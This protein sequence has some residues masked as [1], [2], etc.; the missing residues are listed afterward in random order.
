M[1]Y[2]L[3]SVSKAAVVPGDTVSDIAL[4]DMY[5]IFAATSWD[6]SIYYYDANDALGHKSTTKLGGPLLSGSFCDGNKM[7]AGAV[8][9]MLYVVDVATNQ[10]SEIKAHDLGI[11]KT[12]VYNNIVITGSW[13]KKL[14][15]W[16]LRSNTPLFTH[17]LAHK[18]YAMDI[19]ND[20]LVLALSNNTV[21]TYNINDFQRQRIL[22]TKLK[23]QLRS[24]CCSNDQVLVG[25]IE[26]AIE[27]LNMSDTSDHYYKGHR[28]ANILYAVNCI[29][30]HPHST[31]LVASGG[32][33]SYVLIYNK[34]QRIKT[35]FEKT[36]APVTAGKFSRNGLFYIYATGEDWS[37]GYPVTQCATN[38]CTLDIKKAKIIV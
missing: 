22:R 25:G 24:V 38:V 35:Y 20:N 16:D 7:V 5:D 31:S 15:F 18:V 4:H 17:E 13:D 9:G 8:S 2:N 26:G 36:N 32:S 1:L 3:S 6:G 12:K 23:W 21:V 30:V 19:K 29:D 11:K 34:Q 28:S 14:K 10:I 27:V 37:K 33:D